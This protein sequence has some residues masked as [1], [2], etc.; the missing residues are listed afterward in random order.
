[1][2]LDLTFKTDRDGEWMP[3]EEAEFRDL[4]E[5]VL[6]RSILPNPFC[7]NIGS[8]FDR[9]MIKD[10]DRSRQRSESDKQSNDSLDKNQQSRESEEVAQHRPL[11]QGGGTMST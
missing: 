9:F 1:M 2:E 10:T 6:T 5:D 8:N 4:E 7:G 3:L 11:K